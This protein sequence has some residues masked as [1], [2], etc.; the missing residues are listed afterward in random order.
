MEPKLTNVYEMS[1]SVYDEYINTG[2]EKRNFDEVFRR[3][4]QAANP[5]GLTSILDLCCGT[6]IFPRRWLSQLKNIVCVGV[7]TNQAFLDFAHEQLD[8]KFNCTFVRGDAV[9]K[10][11]DKKFDIVIGT[12]AY[13]HIPDEQK[14]AFLGNIKRHLKKDGVGIIYEKFIF[15]FNSPVEAAR[16]GTNFY[17]ER[18]YD[19]MKEEQLSEVQLFALFNEMYLTAVRKEEFKVP[20]D[21]FIADLKATGFEVISEV[22]LWP[23]DNRFNDPKVGDFVIVFKKSG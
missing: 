17:E 10:I 13:H 21:K 23:E 12:S 18:I 22:K 3:I 7:D 6:G 8:G 20:Y 15:P 2:F 16:S 14:G 1:P 11:I 5:K 9:S 4:K 19:M